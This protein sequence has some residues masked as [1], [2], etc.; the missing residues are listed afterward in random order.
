[1]MKRSDITYILCSVFA[2]ATAFFYCC[3]MWFPVKLPRYYPT[4]HV[5]KW[6]KTKGV[7][8]QGWYGMQ[9]FAYICAALAV[10]A[11]YLVLRRVMREQTQLSS[12][13]TRCLGLV[14]TAVIVVCMAY[15][16]LH[17]FGKWGI[18]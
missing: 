7:P 5:W 4:E 16:L 17:E 11:A 6:V 13:A 18:L 8:S 15:M 9:A 1:M 2:A 14:T 3:T 12:A 10:L